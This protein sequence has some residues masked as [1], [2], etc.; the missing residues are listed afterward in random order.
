MEQKQDPK[1]EFKGFK[2]WFKIMWSNYF[3]QIFVVAFGILVYQLFNMSKC[4]DSITESD[5]YAGQIFAILGNLIP[6]SVC[7]IVG[8][9]AFYQFWVDLRNGR[10]R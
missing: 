8:Y 9:K 10:S 2:K 6:L 7:I 3:I 5:G 1:E 4:V